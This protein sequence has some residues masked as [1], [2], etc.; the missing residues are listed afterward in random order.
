MG[1]LLTFGVDGLAGGDGAVDRGVQE[2]ALSG[3]ARRITAGS[4]GARPG[5]RAGRPARPVAGEVA[6][7]GAVAA[8][9]VVGI[10]QGAT[11]EGE[12][13]AAD[14]ARQ[15][16]AQALELSDPIVEVVAP[17]GREPSSSRNGWGCGCRR[18][19]RGPV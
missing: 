14:A 19:G 13:A 8:E 9:D 7:T 11:V 15:P 6:G 3:H 5:V 18:A 10:G 2:E 4:A 17:G 16:V 1:P 12:A